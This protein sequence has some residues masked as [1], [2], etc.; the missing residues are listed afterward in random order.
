[1]RKL[2]ECKVTFN[3]GKQ[4]KKEEVGEVKKVVDSAA[5]QLEIDSD[6]NIENA[7][8]EKG[9]QI[10]SIWEDKGESKKSKKA[11]TKKE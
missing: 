2:Q 8:N 10:I 4:T 5:E 7:K 11:K 1:M 6:N 3:N 9:I